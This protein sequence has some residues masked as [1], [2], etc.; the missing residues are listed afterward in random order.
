MVCEIVAELSSTKG[1]T[2]GL[3]NSGFINKDVINANF[4]KGYHLIE[5]LKTNRIIYSKGISVQVKDFA[6]YIEKNYVCLVT[7]SNSKYWTYRYEENLNGIDNA[8]VLFCLPE[9]AFKKDGALHT[10]LGTDTE[11]STKRIIEYYSKRW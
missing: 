9:N 3:Y 6:Q 2:Y 1:K 4:Q 11:L 7:L 8:I 5:A 10:F